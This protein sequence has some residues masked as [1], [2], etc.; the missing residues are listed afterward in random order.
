MSDFIL[1]AMLVAALAVMSV[2]MIPNILIIGEP[3]SGKSVGSAVDALAFPGAVVI[4]DPHKDSL[5]RL[6]LTHAEGDILY[7]RLDDLEHALGYD[8]LRPSSHSNPTVRLQE[9]RD[10]AKFFVE[11]MLRRRGG[12]AA[13]TPLLEE[14]LMNVLMTYLYQE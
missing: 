14:H 10:R 1:I 7:D 11:V 4:L 3:G 8:L 12:D 6:V 2:R 9:N 13:A 5:A